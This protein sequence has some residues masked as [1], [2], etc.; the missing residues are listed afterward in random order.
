MPNKSYKPFIR[1]KYMQMRVNAVVYA[2]LFVSKRGR[3]AQ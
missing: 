2:N 1:T 3:I